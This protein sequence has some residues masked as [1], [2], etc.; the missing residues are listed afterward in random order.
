MAPPMTI[1]GTGAS[2]RFRLIRT[3]R[4]I[5]STAA[6]ALSG[7]SEGFGAEFVAAIYLARL[8]YLCVLGTLFTHYNRSYSALT[9][10]QV[11]VCIL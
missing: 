5:G 1:S 4:I 8:I 3:V 9:E 7:S 10:Q 2:S 11:L 6:A